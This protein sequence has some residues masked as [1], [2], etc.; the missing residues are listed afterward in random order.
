MGGLNITG[1]MKIPLP[2]VL[3]VAFEKK[4][5]M[6][7]SA[8]LKNFQKYI[9][10]KIIILSIQNYTGLSPCAFIKNRNLVSELC[11]YIYT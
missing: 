10:T 7:M 5:S 3:C 8:S 2:S 9:S 4:N 6:I 1:T 11:E